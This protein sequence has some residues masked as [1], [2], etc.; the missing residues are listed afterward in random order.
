MSK[1]PPNL[2]LDLDVLLVEDN[3]VNQKVASRLIERQGCRVTVAANGR[4]AITLHR[5]RSFDIILMDLQMPEMNGFEATKS[6]RAAEQGTDSHVPII[7]LTAN[8]MA[9]DR[10]I[11]LEAGMDDH[12][13]KPIDA[14]RLLHVLQTYANQKW[15]A[16]QAL[17]PV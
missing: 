1:A 11:C 9:G 3:L 5:N 15:R 7:A 6:I 14:G 10:E 4:E 2:Q 17:S 13:P 12:L 8:A 16:G